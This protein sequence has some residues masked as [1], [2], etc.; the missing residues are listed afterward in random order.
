[1]LRPLKITE[2][3]LL[4]LA[5]Q[6]EE[7]L[8]EARRQDHRGWIETLKKRAASLRAMSARLPRQE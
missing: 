8:I 3:R 2:E 7:D 5:D 4:Q 6:N 1:M